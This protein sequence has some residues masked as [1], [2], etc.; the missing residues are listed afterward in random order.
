M[1]SSNVP[2]RPV[3]F[4]LV[5]VAGAAAVGCEAPPDASATAEAKPSGAPVTT[6]TPG[7]ATSA[8]APK[9]KSDGIPAPADV[10][11][12]PADATKTSS[13][14]A[15][16]NIT[17][18]T[19]TEHPTAE[20][21]V[22]VHYTGWTADGNMFDSSKKRGQ[23][24]T[25]PLNGVIKGWTEGVQ[26]MVVGDTTRFWIPAELAYG[27]TPKRPG[28]PSGQLTFDIELI[29]IKKTPPPPPVPEDVKEAPKTAKKTKSGIAY[30]VLTKG[31]GTKHPT[32][33]D[34]VQVN[35]SGWTTDGK[36][37]DSSVTRGEPATFPLSGVIKGWTEGVQLMVEGEKTRFWIPA[38]LAYG[39]KPQRPGAPSG[40]LVFDIEL[41][42]IL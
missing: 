2:R 41:L 1:M 32:E 23:P 39:D 38:D 14:L 4:G 27:A 16:K 34:R 28:A 19:G 17:K 35:Y 20:D 36:M 29:E 33:K 37:F 18:G 42:K 25:F 12:P 40:M 8:P 26:L 13:G 5:G 11:A 24:A 6:A 31:T 9:P 22:T 21:K 10:A 30:R 15:Y 7:G 3:L